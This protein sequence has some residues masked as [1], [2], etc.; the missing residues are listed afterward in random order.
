M[1]RFTVDTH[2][3][4]ELGEMLVGRDSTALVELIKNAYDADAKLITVTGNGLRTTR[5]SIILADDGN[6]MNQDVFEK[7]FLRVASRI[8]EEGERR[9]PLFKRRFTGAKG[10]GRLAAHKLSSFI[11]V[12][13]NPSSKV[14]KNRECIFASIDWKMIEEE[15]E[16]LEELY[17]E[18]DDDEEAAAKKDR[19][20]P[21]II[22]E[23]AAR[24]GCG[25]QIK[26]TRLRR[27]WTSKELERFFWEI[28]TFRPPESLTNPSK[29]FFP[30]P[31]YFKKIKTSDSASS[32]PGF[33]VVL[34]GDF[35]SSEAYFAAQVSA[36]SWILE[37]DAN[38][39]KK[40]VIYTIT[41]T[42]NYL[43]DNPES[44]AEQVE[45]ELDF[46]DEIQGPY[47]Q[48]RV[49]IFEGHSASQN[50]AIRKWMGKME[51]IRIYMEGFRVLPYGESGNDWLELDTDYK[52][53]GR[54]LSYLKDFEGLEFDIEKSKDEGL[55]GP[56][57]SGVFGAVFLTQNDS[58]DL[59]M[60]VNREGFIH[61]SSFDSLQ[62]IVRV[63]I[64]L[65][66]RERHAASYWR[67]MKWHEDRVPKTIAL[68]ESPKS[69]K[70]AVASNITSASQLAKEARQA[71]AAGKFEE[72]EN[73]IRKAAS[74]FQTGS[75][76]SSRLLTEPELTRILAAI[77]TQMAA[78][79]HEVKGLLGTSLTLERAIAKIKKD[80]SVKSET[81]KKL[82]QLS[83]AITD[84]RKSVER[85]ASYLTD[86]TSPD[87]RR[88]RS[89]QKLNERFE[90]AKRIVLPEVSR[91]ELLIENEIPVSFKTLPMFPAEVTLIFSNLLSNAVKASDVN[92]S[93]LASAEK[94]QDGI[95]VFLSNTGKK[96]NVPKAEK[97]FRPFE[98]TS[99][100]VSPLLGQG[101][102]MGL[103]LT[104]NM[105]EE[106]GGSVKFVNPVD[107]YSTTIEVFFPAD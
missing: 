87:A 7:G 68:D 86:I 4:R 33:K 93:I 35:E 13:S 29:K 84:M 41:P 46:P 55:S 104:R 32:D 88:R 65:S 98:S 82:A 40:K 95:I 57:N 21:I 36:A 3:F 85:Q 27:K 42:K 18:P 2:I 53:R 45:Y 102:G 19:K 15:F 1:T 48:S 23:S 37:I 107:G 6:G 67:R 66:T 8:K 99:T 71:A 73:K 56:T 59:R 12:D 31:L 72:A 38:K 51:G 22:L 60:I 81:R 20:T 50:K 25:T 105:I 92:G 75:E 24:S 62:K 28:Q 9:S 34:K 79:V 90:S 47:F 52:K 64:D 26:L 77:G 100:S 10:I 78:F 69:L 91:K 5:G 83:Q 43:R 49:L 44:D 80:T 61:D 70:E 101:M 30:D 63:G 39:K 76:I 11:S 96:V 103:P 16:T 74:K 58:C 54:T 17:Q 94:T 14:F 106:Y 97:W 89:R